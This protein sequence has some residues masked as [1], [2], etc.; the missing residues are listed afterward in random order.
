MKHFHDFV[1]LRVVSILHS[2]G[3]IFRLL[4][5][6]HIIHWGNNSRASIPPEEKIYKMSKQA[7]VNISSFTTDENMWILG[8]LLYSWYHMTYWGY[9]IWAAIWFRETESPTNSPSCCLAAWHGQWQEISWWGLWGEKETVSESKAVQ[10]S[11]AKCSLSLSQRKNCQ[12]V[13][14]STVKMTNTSSAK[15]AW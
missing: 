1:L 4:E 9:E 15:V 8:P 13:I 3:K 12:K 2:F 14:P 7:F 5:V 10:R 6:R 11:S